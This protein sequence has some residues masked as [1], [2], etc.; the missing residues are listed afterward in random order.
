M[1][2][3][4]HET[5][6]Q[7]LHQSRILIHTEC[8]LRVLRPILLLKTSLKRLRSSHIFWCPGFRKCFRVAFGLLQTSPSISPKLFFKTSRR[9]I[10]SSQAI[11][12]HIH[13]LS[14]FVQVAIFRFSGCRKC[15][16]MAFRHV[17]TSLHLLHQCRILRRPEGRFRLLRAIRLL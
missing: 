11:R 12:L 8:R 7:R 9:E 2:F 1:V 4:H 17:E 6:L 15:V 10:M 14:D 16:R 5:S 13:H 3:R